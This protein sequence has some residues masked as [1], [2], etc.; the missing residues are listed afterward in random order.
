MR[1]EINKMLSK[2]MNKTYLAFWENHKNDF[3][4]RNIR[5]IDQKNS[6][7]ERK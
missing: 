6:D 7:K 1:A 3:Y 4:D 5:N 2:Q